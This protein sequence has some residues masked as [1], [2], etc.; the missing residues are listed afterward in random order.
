ME[1]V[2]TTDKKEL[3]GAL[4]GAWPTGE[5]TAL[6]MLGTD[7]VQPETRAIPEEAAGK[8]LVEIAYLGVCGSDLELL[9]GTSF[10]ITEG[11]NRYPLI[12]GHEFSGTVVAVGPGVSGFE[13]GDRVVGITNVNCGACRMCL[14]GKRHLC[15]TYAEVGLQGYPGAA[16]EYFA[17]PA[18]SLAKIPEELSLKEAALV[19]PATAVA[20]AAERVRLSYEDR[21][22]V[23]GTG[24]LGLVAVQLA[25]SAAESVDAIGVEQGGL[26]LAK[27]LGASRAMRPEE[28]PAGA[29][30]VVM[31]AS[32]A[33]SAF[34]SVPRLLERGGRAAMIG[35]PNEPT[36]RFVPA[37][38]VLGDLDLLGIF[39]GAEHYDQTIG[40]FASGRVRAE[41][42]IDRVLPA[43]EVA[44]AFR[45]LAAGGRARPKVLLEFAG[46]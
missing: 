37:S 27:E 40:L 2:H 7:V 13:T 30:S 5:M 26:D 20:H 46:S 24:A 15:E 25:L 36:R 42:L 23:I 9:H 1:R 32:G 33:L 17:A 10:Y 31:E 22:A 8:V 45:L 44:L 29:Y 28:A 21:V 34:E 19:E 6:V 43:N 35:V 38:I 14:R 11:L 41:P 16:S 12:F 4:G 39:S 18:G 3:G